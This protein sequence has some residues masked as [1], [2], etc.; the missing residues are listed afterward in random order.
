MDGG[1]NGGD[2]LICAFVG[3]ARCLWYTADQD[4]KNKRA[5]GTAVASKAEAFGRG[6]TIGK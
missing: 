1:V 2:G 5:R 6:W 4:Y 3:G